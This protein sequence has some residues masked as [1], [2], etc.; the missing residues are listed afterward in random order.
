M[1]SKLL[2]ISLNGGR[3][4]ILVVAV[5]CKEFVPV[6]HGCMIV[7]CRCCLLSNRNERMPSLPVLDVSS[8]VSPGIMCLTA[9]LVDTSD[10]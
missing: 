2:V 7:S 8:G 9:S 3:T 10:F 6:F 5:R 1:K 4:K